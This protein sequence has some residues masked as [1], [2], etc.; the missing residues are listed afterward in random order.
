VRVDIDGNL[1][2][3]VPGGLLHDLEG[4]ALGDEETRRPVAELWK[5]KR[6]M[7]QVLVRS[8]TDGSERL[9]HSCT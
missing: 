5:L 2:G 9:S 1:V 3:R 6:P 7:Q 8:F 4:H